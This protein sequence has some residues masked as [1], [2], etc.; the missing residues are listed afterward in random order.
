MR[1]TEIS[2]VGIFSAL[3]FAGGYLFIAVPNV[4]IFTAIVFLSGI[5]LGSRKGML[6]GLIAQTLYSILNPY[7]VAPLP[8]LVA[9]VTHRILVGYVGGR[10]QT[11][12]NPESTAWVSTA[13]L[14]FTG[15]VLTLLF[16]FMTDAS[17]FF[18]SGF[19]LEQMKVTFTLGLGWYVV[20]AIGNTLIFAIVLPVIIKGV[21]RVDQLRM[22]NLS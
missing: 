11:M 20:H 5:L 9:Q 4:E 6:V 3:A 8:L 13:Y 17:S 21:K 12:L 22:A 2:A 15:L 7:G 18:I 19:S 14:G 1:L 10:F 16:D